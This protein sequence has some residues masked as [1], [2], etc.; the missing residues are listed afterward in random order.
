MAGT[1]FETFQRPSVVPPRITYRSVTESVLVDWGER[2]RERRERLGLSQEAVAELAG[3]R[4]GTWSKIE[5]GRHEP[6]IAQK[7]AIA[8][9]LG[10]T[11]AK[12]FPYPAVRP[13][14]PAAVA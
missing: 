6:R 12:L 13:E 8:A 3:I 9:A 10:T 2:V 1:T 7:F 11:P 4:Q 14:L 5:A